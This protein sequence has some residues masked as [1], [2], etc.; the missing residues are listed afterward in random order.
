MGSAP[1]AQNPAR[2]AL[3]S[4]KRRT[5]VQR[6]SDTIGTIAAGLAKAQAHE[7]QKAAAHPL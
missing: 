2:S 7:Q 5:A 3:I 4:L 6:S 1:S